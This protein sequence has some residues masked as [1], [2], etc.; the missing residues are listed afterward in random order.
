MVDVFGESLSFLL[1]V[2]G[3]S[4]CVLEAFAPGAHFIV[5]GVALLAAGL[6]GLAFPPLAT[7]I[8]LG[9]LVLGVGGLALYLYRTYDFYQ[10]TDRGTTRDAMDLL[11]A[12]AKVIETVTPDGGRVKL[13]D[14][15]G[16]DPTYSARSIDG[17]IETGTRVVVVDPRGGNVLRVAAADQ[18]DDIDRALAATRSAA[19]NTGSATAESDAGTASESDTASESQADTASDSQPSDR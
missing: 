19:E 13:T 1:V 15:G 10:G 8:V 6:I 17:T 7:P 5:I 11:G 16:F 3:V 9:A 4:L 2:L 14:R 12:E 18:A